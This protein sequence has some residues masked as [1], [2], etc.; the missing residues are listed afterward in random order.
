MHNSARF[1]FLY[2]FQYMRHSVIGCGRENDDVFN[3]CFEGCSCQAVECLPESGCCCVLRFGAT[4]DGLGRLFDLRDGVPIMECNDGCKCN[5]S[6]SNR[7]VQRGVSTLLQVFDTR[8][9][10]FGVRTLQPI[11]KNHFV[12]EYAGELI[13]FESAMRRFAF[14]DS[15]PNYILAIREHFGSNKN[16]FVTYIDATYVGNVGRLINHSCNPNLIMIPVRVQNDVPLIALFAQVDI[17]IGD[18]LTYDY[19]GGS[20]TGVVVSLEANIE[21]IQRRT[22]CFCGSNNCRLVIPFERGIQSE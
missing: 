3:E 17:G 9:R 13:S 14:R 12:C 22:P 1:S 6:C 5:V 18:E 7:V 19:S 8:Q 20:E 16:A 10:G 11:S 4:Y 21:N 2:A 15:Q